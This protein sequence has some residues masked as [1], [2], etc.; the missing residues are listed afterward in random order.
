MEGLIKQLTLSIDLSD[1]MTYID[2]RMDLANP[3]HWFIDH[4]W[5]DLQGTLI[6]SQDPQGLDTFSQKLLERM[7]LDSNYF[8]K[9]RGVLVPN[10]SKY[11]V[12]PSNNVLTLSQKRFGSG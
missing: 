6:V 8:T 11:T 5:E 4:P 1:M 7:A 3:N 12:T 9:S 2:S 10:K